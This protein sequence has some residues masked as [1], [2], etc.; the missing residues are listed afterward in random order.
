MP[1]VASGSLTEFVI[2][3]AI[4]VT[5]PKVCGNMRLGTLGEANRG[6]CLP[7]AVWR[8]KEPEP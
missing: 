8:H 4:T 7:L 5:L 3:T 6:S 2:V 1:A